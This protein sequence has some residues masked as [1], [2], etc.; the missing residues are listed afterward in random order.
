MKIFVVT[1]GYPP[2]EI[3][4]TETYVADLVRVLHDWGHEAEIGY[5]RQEPGPGSI[6]VCRE[7]RKGTRV[8]V[9]RVPRPPYQLEFLAFD[10]ALRE[11]LISELSEIVERVA[12]DVVHV[13]PLQIGFESYLMQR[14]HAEGR[15]VVWT[16]HTATASCA[17][18]DLLRF[19]ARVCDGGIMQRR[20]SACLMHRKGMPR[21]FALA[22]NVLPV[23]TYRQL[24]RT[25]D[26]LRLRR[27][28]SFA[29]LPLLIAERRAAWKRAI[30]ACD[31]VVAV[32][33]W[34]RDVLRRN[35]VPDEKVLL[36][37]HGRTGGTPAP[38]FRPGARTRFGYLGR[39]YPGKGIDVLLAA[40]REVGGEARFDLEIAAP[41]SVA[42]DAG[43]AAL[44]QQ[45]RTLAEQDSR[46]RLRHVEPAAV[47]ALLST[48]DALIVPSTAMET[49]PQVVLEAFLART[50][51]IGSRRGGIAELVQDGE[52]GFLFEP[53]SSAELAGLLRSFAIDPTPLRAL[54]GRIPAVRG[55]DE[56]ARDMLAVYERLRIGRTA[57]AVD[58]A[59][60]E[61]CCV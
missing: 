38:A 17:R 15:P 61:A 24:Y 6:A 4:G 43:Q 22:A 49:G 5:I 58:Q 19:G 52:T 3:G 35:G 16:Y 53:G 32:S 7:V 26:A 9:V 54:R 28:R 1:I 48:W 20:C 44:L 2:N 27:F 30:D 37:R 21:L 33:E 39:I 56:V 51:V 47:F 40:L 42:E 55:A 41:A 31:C 8:H 13:H 46:V 23:R 60:A 34:V 50:P 25:F 36:S 59:A 14:V 10:D 18:G 57:R 45:V 29:S 12:P 11:R